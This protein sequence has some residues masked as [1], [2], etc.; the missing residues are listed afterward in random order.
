MGTVPDV[1][2]SRLPFC[3]S[4]TVSTTSDENLIPQMPLSSGAE[5]LWPR[6]VASGVAEAMIA[7]PLSLYPLWLILGKIALPILQNRVC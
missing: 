4:I 3:V 7:A 5:V 1:V 6:T 2:S